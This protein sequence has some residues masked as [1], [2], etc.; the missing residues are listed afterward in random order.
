MSNII[1]LPGLPEP[2]PD[3]QRI[4]R[5]ALGVNLHKLQRLLMAQ[6]FVAKESDLLT[7]GEALEGIA[8]QVIDQLQAVKTAIDDSKGKQDE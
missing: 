6:S 3:T 1:K 5:E 2:K 7:V 8:E 4:A